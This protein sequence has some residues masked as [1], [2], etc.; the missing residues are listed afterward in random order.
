[1]PYITFNL[2]WI[3]DLKVRPYTLKLLEKKH[4]EKYPLY[5]S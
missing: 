1:M 2:K 3:K 4:G 5:G